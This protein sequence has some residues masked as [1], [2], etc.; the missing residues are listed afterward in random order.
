MKN[1][2]GLLLW[3][4]TILNIETRGHVL[5]VNLVG[6]VIV[7]YFSTYKY[8]QNITMLIRNIGFPLFGIRQ[9]CV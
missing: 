8:L 1:F 7:Q 3:W 5:G 2:T 6:F 4:Q 9:P